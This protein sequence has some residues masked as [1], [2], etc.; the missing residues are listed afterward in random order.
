MVLDF[1][2]L[3]QDTAHRRPITFNADT[4][5]LSGYYSDELSAYRAKREWVRVFNIYFLLESERDYELRISVLGDKEVFHLECIFSS[6]CGRYAFWRLING[7][8][9]EAEGELGVIEGA[10]LSDSFFANL[11]R[12]SRKPK[13]TPWI[14]TGDESNRG[15]F[16]SLLRRLTRGR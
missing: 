12:T 8:A 13:E 2:Q 4:V 7:Q 10:G 5:T 16:K 6:A 14:L 3:R 11:F 15:T 9:P 1:A